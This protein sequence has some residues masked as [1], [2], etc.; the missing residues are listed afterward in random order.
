MTRR[1]LSPVQRRLAAVIALAALTLVCFGLARIGPLNPVYFQM[2]PVAANGG[3]TE[4]DL[5]PVPEGPA[6][7]FMRAPTQAGGVFPL[8]PIARLI[9]DPLPPPQFQWLCDQGG[10]LIVHLGNGKEVVYGPCYRPA[11]IDRLW[12]EIR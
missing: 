3:V 6:V 2:V 5:Q 9:P 11:S 8:A 10:D 7:S 12:S 1:T 4:I